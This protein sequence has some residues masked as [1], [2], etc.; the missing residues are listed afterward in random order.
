MRILRRSVCTT[1]TLFLCMRF[2]VIH[3]Y[4]LIEQHSYICSNS[5]VYVHVIFEIFMSDP[6]LNIC[7]VSN[8]D[9]PIYCT[10]VYCYH[11]QCIF[12]ASSFASFL[13]DRLRYL[14]YPHAPPY[15]HV[16]VS[17]THDLHSTFRIRV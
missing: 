7:L 4:L 13:I 6:R 9:S 16:S 12:S 3:V 8:Y 17:L 11:R 5:S 1:S 15:Y 2:F 10:A 14:T